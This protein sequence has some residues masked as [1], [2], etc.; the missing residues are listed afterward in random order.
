[1]IKNDTMKI[2]YI[3]IKGMNVGGGIEKY[4]EE[5]GSRLAAKGHEITVY[6]MK[7]YGSRDGVYKGM[8]LRTVPSVKTKSLE[9]LS[10]SFL[11]TLIN[12]MQDKSDIVHFHAFG[13]AMF[14]FLPKWIGK[15][16]VVQGH[17]LEWRR[18]KWGPWGGPF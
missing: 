9:K 2:T 5:I 7:Q 13:P 12:C 3:V 11:S 18:S 15:K 17:G 8:N 10:T 1:M 14:C 4:T 16:V 6:C